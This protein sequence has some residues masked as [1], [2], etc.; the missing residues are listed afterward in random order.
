MR[1]YREQMQ[2]AA[3]TKTT[4]HN[5]LMIPRTRT[6]VSGRLPGLLV[7]VCLWS[8]IEQLDVF[9]PV[10]MLRAPINSPDLFFF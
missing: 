3:W 10:F 4:C 1:R 9:T 2:R 6:V 8:T 7:C 5:R